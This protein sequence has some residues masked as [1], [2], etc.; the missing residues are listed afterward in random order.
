MDCS[1]SGFPVLHHLP[2]FAQTHVHWVGDAIQQVGD[3]SSV[4]L[5][6]SK[7]RNSSIWVCVHYHKSVIQNNISL[8]LNLVSEPVCNLVFTSPN[9][10]V[11]ACNTTL[12]GWDLTSSCL[13]HSDR[14]KIRKDQRLW[15]LK[16]IHG[17]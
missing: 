3:L 8:S 5:S 2:E 11:G 6:S 14:V 7:N 16:W 13:N 1:I 4:F 9:S 10:K 17:K 15:Y 12:A